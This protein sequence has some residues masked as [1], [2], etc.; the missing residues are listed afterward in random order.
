MTD[1]LNPCPFCG[2][3]DI[4]FVINDEIGCSFLYGHAICNGC[5]ACVPC[6]KDE[7]HPDLLESWNR[8]AEGVTVCRDC[9]RAERSGRHLYCK[10]PMGRSGYS[11][12]CDDDFCSHGE[13][14]EK[15]DA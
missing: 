14:R 13:P 12:V 11:E 6:I 2:S 9:V 5:G 4:R 7:Y 10:A 3:T 8:R 1:N 15:P